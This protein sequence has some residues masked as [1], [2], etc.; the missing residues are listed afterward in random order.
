MLYG[1]NTFC[2]SIDILHAMS[3]DNNQMAS[4]SNEPPQVAPTQLSRQA[5]R[6]L[7]MQAAVLRAHSMVLPKKIV[8]NMVALDN[9]LR[10][11]VLD[12][13]NVQQRIQ[14]LRV[15][16]NIIAYE[17]EDT[18]F[19]NVERNPGLTAIALYNNT[20]V[21]Y[22]S[23]EMMS[24]NRALHINHVVVLPRF[25]KR[26]IGQ[27]LMHFAIK[28]I[29]EKLSTVKAL[30]VHVFDY[31]VDLIRL[32]ERFDFTD[33]PEGHRREDPMNYLFYIRKINQRFDIMES[34]PIKR[35]KKEITIGEVT[36]DNIEEVRAI[37]NKIRDFGESRG[38]YEN[39]AQYPHL[40][41]FA[42]LN[43]ERIGVMCCAEVVLRVYKLHQIMSL[44]VVEEDYV[45]K[46][47]VIELLLNKAIRTAE[48]TD[49]IEM[50]TYFCKNDDTVTLEVMDRLGFHLWKPYEDFYAN[51]YDGKHLHI[52]PI[53]KNLPQLENPGRNAA[54]RDFDIDL[55]DLDK[56]ETTKNS[57]RFANVTE[58]NLQT[59]QQLIA[60]I[61]PTGHINEE[62]L[63]IHLRAFPK[64]TC[65]AF[66]DGAPCG[67]IIC[68]KT[69]ILG[70]SFH[71]SILKL[72]VI[73]DLRGNGIGGALLR[74]AIKVAKE[75]DDVTDVGA[76]VPLD[77]DIA[78][79]L[80][81]RHHFLRTAT[82]PKHGTN[83]A[84]H[85]FTRSTG[86]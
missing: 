67:F 54:P 4:T 72:G 18:F 7:P 2:R 53:E 80:F 34:P 69:P 76:S 51:N 1:T 47:K 66:F 24:S 56:L 39:V 45:L 23:C 31:Q 25:R 77:S 71:L 55:I 30:C 46:S 21:G 60:R 32:F 82:I 27:A 44:G 63:R 48:N 70:G 58:D 15:L 16:S 37:N 68:V 38:L 73:T 86:N 64:L 59:F 12:E 84:R 74:R 52:K 83:E 61:Y 35:Q 62:R 43:D 5:L 8:E 20:P 49:D 22:I 17:V 29:A 28:K 6:E 79:R 19:E 36:P 75:M 3:S 81:E 41:S 85:V 9:N 57:L 11:E 10:I 40:S 65:L 42:I 78:Q 13:Q 14:E 26:G 50:V 33:C